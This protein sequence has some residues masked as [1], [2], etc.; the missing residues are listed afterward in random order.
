MSKLLRL[1]GAIKKATR[2]AINKMAQ[3]AKSRANRAIR[4]KYAVSVADLNKAID[5]KKASNS[6]PSAEFKIKGDP[7]PL[8]AF[9]ARPTKRGI[10]VRI[11]KD[12]GSTLVEGGF[13]ATVRAGKT[14]K[15]KHVVKRRGIVSPRSKGWTEG[16]PRTSPRN[17]PIKALV[18]LGPAAMFDI[19][20]ERAIEDVVRSDFQ[21]LF[22]NELRFFVTRA[23]SGGRR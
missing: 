13:F 19:E 10:V 11:R 20:G 9:K 15:K 1:D 17:L 8:I 18:S 6:N 23:I 14:G 7:I 12:S 16:R 2:S 22:D 21:K 5:L 3:R 4:Q